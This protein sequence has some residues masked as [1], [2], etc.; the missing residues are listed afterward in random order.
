[1]RAV[2]IAANAP[3]KHALVSEC[4]LGKLYEPG[5][6]KSKNG[7]GR[8]RL[9]AS[10]RETFS[11]EAPIIVAAISFASRPHFLVANQMMTVAVASVRNSVD[12]RNEMP[13][14][15]VV[16]AGDAN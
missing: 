16:I 2:M 15:A 3:K 11:S 6:S 13:R 9:K 12:P 10:L 7:R 14:M 8:V 5:G 1:M 4:P